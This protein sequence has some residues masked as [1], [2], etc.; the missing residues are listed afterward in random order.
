M[1]KPFL[2]YWRL[3]FKY[4]SLSLISP[5]LLLKAILHWNLSSPLC[6]LRFA[7][8]LHY[9][10][11]CNSFWYKLCQDFST[12][13]LCGHRG[14]SLG[15]FNWH[16]LYYGVIFTSVNI[17]GGSAGI[18]TSLS[19]IFSLEFLILYLV[20]CLSEILVGILCDGTFLHRTIEKL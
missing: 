3:V 10:Y 19:C 14:F 11:S 2:Q 7:H 20:G 5:F 6:L 4:V 18:T 1:P 16:K 9:Y 12:E 13:Q 17:K 15:D 8:Q